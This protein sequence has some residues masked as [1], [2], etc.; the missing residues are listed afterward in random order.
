MAAT[1]RAADARRSWFRRA[2]VCAAGGAACLIEILVLADIA[3]RSLDLEADCGTF[4]ASFVVAFVIG[5]G[6]K[7]AIGMWVCRSSKLVSTL[8]FAWTLLGATWLGLS[9]V[10]AA[11]QAPRET[12]CF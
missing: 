1:A 2:A 3:L 12:L 4:P 9:F 7:V 5:M 10:L 6:A 8:I 11:F